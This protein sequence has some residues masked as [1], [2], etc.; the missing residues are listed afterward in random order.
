MKPSLSP[1]KA[2]FMSTPAAVVST[3]EPFRA[4][5][6]ATRSIEQAAAAFFQEHAQKPRQALLQAAQQLKVDLLANKGPWIA[7][8]ATDAA[9]ALSLDAMFALSNAY[10][11]AA[12]GAA[13][14][15]AQI[16][17]IFLNDQAPNRGR[18]LGEAV[19]LLGLTPPASDQ[20]NATP[21]FRPRRRNDP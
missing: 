18:A 9:P 17:Q 3:S 2:R 10:G 20:A 7:P 19:T 16:T 12:G 5:F 8:G 15:F 14:C 13:P 1:Y 21:D 6:M 11:K 4:T